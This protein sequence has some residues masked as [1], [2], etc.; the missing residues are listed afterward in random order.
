[1]F[2][3]NIRLLIVNEMT[4]MRKMVV[5][6]CRDLGMTD[7]TEAENVADAWQKMNEATSPFRVVISEWEMTQAT[8]MDLLKRIRRDSKLGKTPFILLTSEAGQD[9]IVEAAKAGVS[10]YIVKPFT[11][12]ILKEKIKAAL[13][14]PIKSL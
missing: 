10:A 9:K 12:E 14:K 13:E 7:L 6:A 8:G 4:T 5:D 1:M 11:P 2:D 3:P